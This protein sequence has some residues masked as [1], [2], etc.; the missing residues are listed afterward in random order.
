VGDKLRSQTFPVKFPDVSSVKIIR[1]AGVLWWDGMFGG[2][3]AG[4]KLAAEGRGFAAHKL[5]S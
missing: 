4:G 2:A 1:R 3:V 5:I